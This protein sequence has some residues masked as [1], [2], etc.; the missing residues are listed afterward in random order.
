MLY[1]APDAATRLVQS[2]LDD[3]P[4]H[5]TD[6][7]VASRGACCS[8]KKNCHSPAQR[9]QDDAFPTAAAAAQTNATSVFRPTL[10]VRRELPDVITN[11][12]KKNHTPEG[13]F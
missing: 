4:T 8:P 11:S 5:T 1:Y 13:K 2:R 7:A 3:A 6:S 10:C 12:N 9:L